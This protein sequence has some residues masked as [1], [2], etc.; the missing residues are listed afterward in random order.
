MAGP[1]SPQILDAGPCGAANLENMAA[2]SQGTKKTISFFKGDD[3]GTPIGSHTVF[4]F[5][6]NEQAVGMVQTWNQCGDMLL[7]SLDKRQSVLLMDTETGATK[8]ELSLRREQKNW[9]LDIESI[10]PQQKFG[11]YR[12]TNEYSVYGLGDRGTTVFALSHDARA[13]ENIEEYV[14]KADSH[15]KYKSY[16]FTSH[17]Q[18]RAGHLVLGRTDGAIALYDYIMRSE[19]ASCVIDSH[20]VGPVTSVDVAADGSMIVW[21]TE[22]FVFFTCVNRGHWEKGSKEPKPNVINLTMSSADESKFADELE[23]EPPWQP[24]KF[25]A[26]THKDEHGLYEREIITYCGVLQ[27][28]WSVKEAKRV[29]EAHSENNAQPARLDGKVTQMDGMVYRHMTVGTD[30]DIVALE[31]EVVKSLHF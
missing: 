30:A 27:V 14:I 13:G 6:G 5:E 26:A 2:L 31:G 23:T 21:T 29:W 16:T 3:G 22:E 19:N 20:K 12:Q 10:T 1:I 18:T 11:Q 25:D 15:R 24:V 4:D 7:T 17:A 9:K 28:R 8:S